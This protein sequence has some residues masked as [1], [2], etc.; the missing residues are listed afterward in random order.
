VPNLLAWEGYV[1]GRGIVL[2]LIYIGI[3]ESNAS[4]IF[5]E[6]TTDTTAQ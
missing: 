2:G 3:P 1:Q 5:M 4:F 6:I